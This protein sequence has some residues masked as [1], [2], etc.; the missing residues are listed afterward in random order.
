MTVTAVMTGRELGHGELGHTSR[1]GHDGWRADVRRSR[2]AEIGGRDGEM[3]Q[4]RRVSDHVS[5]DVLSRGAYVNRAS[6]NR[7]GLE[8][9]RLQ[10]LNVFFAH[11]A[12]RR[13]VF[14]AQ[15]GGAADRLAVLAAVE[16]HFRG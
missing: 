14:F 2:H 16:H 1:G 15:K 12:R 13:V 3:L 9:Q 5:F 7:F 11:A 4:G 6:V 10:L 8:H